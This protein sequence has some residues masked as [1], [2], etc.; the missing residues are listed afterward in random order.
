MRINIIFEEL[1][2]E[3]TALEAS[4]IISLIKVR[5][6]ARIMTGFLRII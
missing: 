3:L 4:Q 1:L 2:Q 5:T 6:F